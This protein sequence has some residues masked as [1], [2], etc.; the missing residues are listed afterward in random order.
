MRFAR[1]AAAAWVLLAGLTAQSNAATFSL[2]VGGNLDFAPSNPTSLS[3]SSPVSLNGYLASSNGMG[4]NTISGVAGPGYLGV[5]SLTALSP[6]FATLWIGSITTA[7]F[8][9]TIVF[10]GPGASVTTSLNFA[11]DGTVSEAQDSGVMVVSPILTIELY[12]LNYQSAF[13]LD[14]AGQAANMTGLYL[15]VPDP[16]NVDGVFGTP[17]VTVPTNTPV[18]LRV[19]F[20]AANGQRGIGSGNTVVDYLD[21]FT[22]ASGGPVFDLPDG[23]TANAPDLGIVDNAYEVR[24]PVAVGLIL[25]ALGALRGRRRR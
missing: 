24:E 17:G 9:D 2:T 16:K 23:Y 14:S 19:S 13:N 1:A 7:R 22:L 21:T 15:S 10:T 8:E 11:L 4:T 12:T 18:L 25:G 6:A 20:T 3:S 5:D